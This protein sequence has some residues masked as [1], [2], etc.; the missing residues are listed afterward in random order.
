[1]KVLK[2]KIN[3]RGKHEVT[4]ELDNDEKLISFNDECFYRLGGQVGD[5]VQGHVI[6]E[7]EGVYWCSIRQEWQ[8]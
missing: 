5:V 3:Q 6:T 2:Q 4:V 1:M 8:A 7:C